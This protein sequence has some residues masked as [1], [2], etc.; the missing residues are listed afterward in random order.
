M[1]CIVLFQTLLLCATK[2]NQ[3]DVVKYLLDQCGAN[4]CHYA[5]DGQNV[6][7]LAATLQ[8]HGILVSTIFL[9]LRLVMWK[10]GLDHFSPGW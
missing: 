10:N 2:K 4:P 1:C 6:L 8:D 5:N 3:L 9:R 7:H